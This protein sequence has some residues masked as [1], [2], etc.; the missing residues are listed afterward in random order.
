MGDLD[1]LGETSFKD[2]TF[3]FDLDFDFDFD[4]DFDEDL[5]LFDVEGLA[6]LC[7]INLMALTMFRLLQ[8]EEEG[9]RVENKFLKSLL[10]ILSDFIRGFFVRILF[11]LMIFFFSGF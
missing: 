6:F 9:P 8:K 2:L 7:F 1:F 4:L 3:L 11:T 5:S 10:L